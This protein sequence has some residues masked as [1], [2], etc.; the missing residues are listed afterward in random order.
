M[1]HRAH[2]HRR[3]SVDKRVLEPAAVY[4][5][6]VLAADGVGTATVTVYDGFN[7]TGDPIDFF[8]AAVSGRD[9][10]YMDDGIIL[11]I[12]L[13]IDLGSNVSFFTVIYDPTPRELG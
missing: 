10:N 1:A 3:V 6:G 9:R 7:T 2:V 8:S 11:R 13:Y 5:G 4:H 12:G